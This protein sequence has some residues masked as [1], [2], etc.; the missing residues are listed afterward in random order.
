MSRYENVSKC[1]SAFSITSSYEEIQADVEFIKSCFYRI[2][3][4][5]VLWTKQALQDFE[6]HKGECQNVNFRGLI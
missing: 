5:C 6:K 3:A 1:G 2:V 4:F